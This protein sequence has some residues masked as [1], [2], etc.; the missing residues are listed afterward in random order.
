MTASLS[1]VLKKLHVIFLIFAGLYFAKQ[2][3]MPLCI[4]G[5]LATLFLPLCNWLEKKKTPNAIAI[6]I[7]LIV[8]LLFLTILISLL[9]FKISE[10][11]SDLA[12]IKEKAFKELAGM[13]A[14]KKLRVIIFKINHEKDSHYQ[15][16][17]E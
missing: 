11:L 13:T 17:S 5:L 10:L 9:G 15:R 2:L 1:P 4:G 8:F 14:R 16:T 3:L 12:S 7:C 6:L